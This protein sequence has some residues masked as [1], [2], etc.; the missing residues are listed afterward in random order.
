MHSYPGKPYFDRISAETDF[1]RDPLEKVYRL[2][3]LVRTMSS[4]PDVKGKLSLKGGTAIQF[5]HFGIRRLSVDVDLNYVGSVEKEG[6]ERDRVKIRDMLTRIFREYG[7]SFGPPRVHHSEEQFELSYINSSGNRD[8]VKVEV[9]YS[10]RLPVLPLGTVRLDHPFREIG[11]VSTLSY[12]FEEIMAMK[13][14]A[15]LTRCVPRD[16]Y[17]V[18]LLA[19]SA[20]PFDRALF[21][22]LA[23]FYLCLAPVDA[24]K[25]TANPIRRIDERDVKRSLLPLLRRRDHALDL[26]AMKRSVI[27]TVEGIVSFAPSERR[28][29]DAFY[30]ERRFD[31]KLLFE[32]ISIESDLSTH[33]VVQWRLMEKPE[34]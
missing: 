12:R 20:M 31:Q 6:M 3:E 26:E 16:L 21:R 22:K 30:Q 10:E 32:D 15:L 28:F 4:A 9:N 18:H 1:N 13:T 7:Y 24:R 2:V 14:R 27:A 33:P 8:R 17:D 34:R 5:V 29:L 11:E 23:I 19:T 25:V